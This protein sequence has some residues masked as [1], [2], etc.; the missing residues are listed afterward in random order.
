LGQDHTIN[1]YY[2]EVA[3]VIGWTGDFVHDL[4][5]PVGM[6]QKLCDTSRAQE[7]GWRAPTSLRTGIEETY[8]FYCERYI[9]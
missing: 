7:W 9:R 6:K 3:H 5:R 2:E 1:S 8:K 4:T